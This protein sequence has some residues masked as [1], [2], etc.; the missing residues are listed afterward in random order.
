MRRMQSLSMDVED[1]TEMGLVPANHTVVEQRLPVG[2]VS[3]I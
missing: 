1:L 2:L 3:V